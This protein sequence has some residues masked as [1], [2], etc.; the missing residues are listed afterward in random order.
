MGT[1]PESK[2]AND[3]VGLLEKLKTQVITLS[4][5]ERQGHPAVAETHKMLNALHREIEIQRQYSLDW[6]ELDA[7]AVK[8]K[9]TTVQSEL[10]NVSTPLWVQDLVDRLKGGAAQIE[11]LRKKDPGAEL[12]A[13]EGTTKMPAFMAASALGGVAGGSIATGMAASAATVS[14]VMLA[15]SMGGM[16]AVPAIDYAADTVITNPKACA[17]AKAVVYGGLATGAAVFAPA[18]LI[19]LGVGLGIGGVTSFFKW[20]ARKQ[21]EARVQEARGKRE[22][23]GTMAA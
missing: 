1:P 20:Y 17:V 18:A 3:M 9:A 14:G 5:Q 2:S 23:Q 16:L 15:G 22:V 21:E 11:K 19:P 4:D 13:V 8:E 10:K 6:S 7:E 12:E